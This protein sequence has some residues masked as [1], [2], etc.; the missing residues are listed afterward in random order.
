MKIDTKLFLGV[1]SLSV[2]IAAVPPASL[3]DETVSLNGLQ[4][5]H[6]ISINKSNPRQLYLATH[7]GLFLASSDGSVKQVSKR[8]DDLMGFAP[9][10]TEPNILFASGHPPGGGNLGFLRS[11]DSGKSW[12]KLS[13]GVNGPVDFHAMDVSKADPKVIYGSFKSLQAS[14]DGGGTWTI[15]GKPPSDVFDIAAS[16]VDSNMVYAATRKGLMMSKDSGKTW[17]MGYIVMK[18]ATMVHASVSDRLY[19]FIYGVGL[20]MTKEPSLA[21][22][23]LSTDFGD[24]YLVHMADDPSDPDRLYAVVDTGAVMISKDGGKTWDSFENHD[25]VTAEKIDR[26]RQLFEEN[27][28]ECHGIRGVGERPDDMYAEDEFGFVAPPLDNSAHG[29]HHS[30]QGIVETILNGSERNERMIPWKDNLS[31]EDAESVVTYIKSL[32]S[33]RSL[34]C[35]GARHMSCM[36]H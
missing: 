7:E 29:W 22:K 12:R 11:E 9:H 25:K 17:N 8:N 2:F 21:W 24:R 1:L 30:D 15:Q 28:Q 34:A 5:I 31:R 3:A 14:R 36:S 4:H 6:A 10:P 27:C 18:P 19:A 33:F 26:G 16:S 32:W 23:K 20:V 35:Q 13:D